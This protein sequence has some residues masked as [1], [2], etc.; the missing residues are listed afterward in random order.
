MVHIK[1][2]MVQT[3]HCDKCEFPKMNLETGL[4]C[5]LTNNK[6]D[7]KVFCPD[8]KFSD[9]FK[10][11]VPKLLNQITELK[12][13]KTSVYFNFGL[14]MGLGLLIIVG[15]YPNLIKYL[16]KTFEPEF[17]YS[18]WKYLSLFLLVDIIGIL[19][20]SIGLWPFKKYHNK[21]NKLES[22]KRE[23]DSVLKS[24]GIETL[25]GKNLH[26]FRSFGV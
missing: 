21:L 14:F 10:E 8:I 1:N 23:I 5:G 6:P 22:E 7:F 18:D 16:K 11:Y 17:S 12:K 13:T 9:S 15:S 4:T 3:K 26:Y 2:R 24:Y 25:P 20:I 19:L